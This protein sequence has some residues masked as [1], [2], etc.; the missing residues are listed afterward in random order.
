[1]Q[2]LICALGKA[3]QQAFLGELESEIK[4]LQ[5]DS[6]EFQRQ[7]LFD[8]Q[9]MNSRIDGLAQDLRAFLGGRNL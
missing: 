4:N 6:L 7:V 1:M 8:L 2:K 3:I 5:S 9:K